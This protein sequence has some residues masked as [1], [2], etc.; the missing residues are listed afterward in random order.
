MVQPSLFEREASSHCLIWLPFCQLQSKDGDSQMETNLM[1][2]P[3]YLHTSILIYICTSLPPRTM[4]LSQRLSVVL[5]LLTSSSCIIGIGTSLSLFSLYSYFTPLVL[6]LYDNLSWCKNNLNDLPCI[7][8]LSSHCPIF[9][10][11]HH[12]IDRSWRRNLHCISSFPFTLHL[13]LAP[14]L[15]YHQ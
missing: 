12:N 4:P 1:F 6:S 8:L 3:Q 2:L 10:S 9:S 5:L 11:F 7:A 14:T 13:A 15:L